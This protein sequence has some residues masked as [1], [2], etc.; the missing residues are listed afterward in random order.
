VKDETVSRSWCLLAGESM[1][2]V[3]Y[4]VTVCRFVVVRSECLY[5]FH[6]VPQLRQLQVCLMF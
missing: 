3:V 1:M 6:I 2:T 5:Q 4:V